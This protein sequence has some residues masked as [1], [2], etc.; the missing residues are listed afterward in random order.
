M[1][2]QSAT[3]A[4]APA[5]GQPEAPPPR[6]VKAS[7]ALMAAV[8]MIRTMSNKDISELLSAECVERGLP[9]GTRFDERAGAWVL[10]EEAPA[11]PEIVK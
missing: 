2:D 1:A 9:E 7:T 11:G 3:T 8:G 5:G 6:V 4:A 10:P